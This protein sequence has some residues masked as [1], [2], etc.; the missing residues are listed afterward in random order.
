VYKHNTRRL[1]TFSGTD[2]VAALRRALLYWHRR[3]RPAGVTLG[4]FLSRCRRGVNE[5][6]IVYIAG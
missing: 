1:I 6:T 3:Q 5:P 2:Q 4:R